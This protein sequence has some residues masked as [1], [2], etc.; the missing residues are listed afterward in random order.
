MSSVPMSGNSASNSPGTK[1]T[2]VYVPAVGPRLRILLLV[3]FA[4]VAVLA[5][6]STYLA[7]VTLAEWYSKQSLQDQFYQLMFL[8]HLGLGLLL[9]L[10]LVAFGLIHMVTS[11]KRKNKRAIRIGYAL[12]AIAIVVLL[13]GIG[14]M[15][16][17]GLN[18]QHAGT[19]RVVYWMHVIA[20]LA[21]IWLYW[22]H[23][24][25]GQKIRWRVGLAYALVV[26]LVVGG[27]IALKMHDPRLANAKKSAEGSKY[28]EPSLARTPNDHFIPAD[29]LMMD[30][31]CKKCHQDVYSGWFHS[32][33]H[34]SSFN[35]PA[36]MASVLETREVAMKRDG[37]VKASRWCA[38]CHDP[39]PFLSG[40]FDDPNY[41]VVNDVTAKAGI[42]CT[43]CHAMTDVNSTVGNG[44]YTLEE[45]IHYPF[46]TSTNPILQYINNQMIKAK[47]AFHKRTFLKDFH[48]SAEFCSTC[49]K[50]GLPK[51]LNHYK[52]FLRGQNHYDTYLLSGVSGHGARSFYY[53][54]VAK[55]NCSECHMPLADSN[56]FGAKDFDGSGKLKV[57][58]HLFP[59]ANTGLAFLRGEPEVV[60][61]HQEF[62]R[63]VT[64]VDIFGIKEGG[65][66]DS[67]LTAPL[68]PEVPVLKPGTRYLL[69]TVVRTLKVGHPLTQGTVDSNEL[70]LDVTVKSGDRVIG[71][72]GGLDEW[73][74]VDRW[75]HFINVFMLDRDG[76]RINRRNPQ[77]IF[78]PL[79][80]HQIPP[81]A[82]QI[83]HFDVTLPQDVRE[84]VTVE[85][86]LQYRKFDQ[87]YM[88]FV[89]KS[90]ESRKQPIPGRMVE[91]RYV[92][93]LPITTLA[94]D[95]IIFPIDGQAPSAD[96]TQ[97]AS[98]E[99][100]NL[101]S[102]V[103]DN[104]KVENKKVEIPEW[105]RWNDYGIGLFLEGQ[106]GSKG[107]F[108]QAAAAFQKVEA[109]G[110]FDGPLNLARVLNAEGRVEEAIEAIQRAATFTDPAP[111]PW[112]ISWLSGLLN[113]QQGDFEA[114]E[115]NFRAVLNDY[116]DEM[117]KRKF[118]FSRDY[119]VINEL[120]ITLFERSK[121]YLGEGEQEE[122]M[123]I[124]RDAVAQFE[125]TLTIDSENVAAH[126][127]LQLLYRE[128]GDE[129]KASKHRD[130]HQ[131][132]KLDDNASDRAMAL[133]R[134]K[135]PAANRA[136]EPLVIYPLQRPGAPG[137]AAVPETPASA[138]SGGGE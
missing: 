22:L 90:A 88:N 68:R 98:G 95:T 35:N 45:P 61:R 132:Y 29:V 27:M 82:G 126:Y 111:P 92:N 13:S 74:E 127:N 31:Y 134:Q 118:D 63:G 119:E 24:L 43:V 14:L 138:A 103:V 39:V 1:P 129:A 16:V 10:P 67:P 96:A 85:V 76:N 33:H 86:K 128:L 6:N 75:S 20:P 17:G 108:R 65:T 122:R 79:Y 53:P 5:A 38:G 44:A 105:Q 112:T 104:K 2:R 42:T 52:E 4:L 106:G 114:A 25:V 77:D 69:E 123:R 64:R 9:I 109:L 78:V 83:V 46:A 26:L 87:E 8:S 48:K 72:S 125:R 23:R 62:L 19:R 110:R 131:R 30:D 81:G 71:R 32:A 133:A 41:D 121:Q 124:L 99:S 28:F 55:T 56:D 37:N 93:E 115:K 117:V 58:D 94:A 130:L 84:P 89:A 100:K 97:N 66:I 3:V 12:F 7:G 47:P 51:E 80:N 73:G 101:E 59:A 113:R 50:V 102:P 135:Y 60:K 21:S 15:Q 11:R 120:G 18:L 136:A 91:G 54:E 57:H 70:W 36:Y 137:L 107:E 49:H 116:T 34:F 40:G